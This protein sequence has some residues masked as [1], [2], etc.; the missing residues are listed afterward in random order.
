MNRSYINFHWIMVNVFPREKA[1]L[2]YIS[3]LQKRTGKISNG[4]ALK[5]FEIRLQFWPLVV[6]CESLSYRTLWCVN[7]NFFQIGVPKKYSRLNF[8]L[9]NWLKFNFSFI[10]RQILLLNNFMLKY[11]VFL[12]IRLQTVA[13]I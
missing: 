10:I 1:K 8:K 11:L 6:P 5:H 12:T 13:E 7:P 2:S 9:L 3:Q 4:N